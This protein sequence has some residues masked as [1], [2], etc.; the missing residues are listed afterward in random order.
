MKKIQLNQILSVL[1][2]GALLFSLGSCKKDDS[3]ANAP[4]ISTS[5][6][7]NIAQNTAKCGGNVTSDGGYAITERGVCWGTNS[8]PTISNSKTTDGTGTGSFT[9]NLTGLAANTTYYVRAYAT[10]SEGT[11]YGSAVSF[12]TQQ[13]ITVTD[14][15][16][17]TY[18]AV[19]IGSQ[20]WMVENLKVTKYRDGTP[21]PNVSDDASWTALTTGAYCNL[22]SP[23]GNSTTY[24]KLYNWYAV[25]DA[26]NI[27]PVGWHVPSDAEWTQLT[28]YLGGETV[29]GGKLKETGT[30]HWESPNTGATNVTG[31]SA[32]P[33]GQRAVAGGFYFVK[34]YGYWWTT[35]DPGLP[36][37]AYYRS[38]ALDNA[39]VYRNYDTK[40]MGFYVRCVKD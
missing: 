1:L 32:L 40:K 22:T 3:N 20:I 6:V 25:S 24:G 36:Y 8:T 26:H 5:A 21:I 16:G 35:S 37:H 19:T 39:S 10:N 2:T 11:G 34:T 33:G 4:V 12:T 9:S 15:D 18:H 38:M 23:Y 30:T 17:N 28:D 29:A 14:I 13:A 31:F 27:C 7:S